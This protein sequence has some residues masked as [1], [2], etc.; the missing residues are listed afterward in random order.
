MFQDVSFGSEASDDQVL[1]VVSRV[2]L[3][4]WKGLGL[5]LGLSALLNKTFA[6]C[7]RT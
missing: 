6:S 7:F 5:G 4:S 1:S 2:F 3:V